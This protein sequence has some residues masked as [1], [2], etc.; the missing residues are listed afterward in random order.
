MPEHTRRALKSSASKATAKKG[1][2]PAARRRTDQERAADGRRGTRQSGTGPSSSWGCSRRR[3]QPGSTSGR[4]RSGGGSAAWRATPSPSTAG[5][6]LLFYADMADHE[7]PWADERPGEPRLDPRRPARRELRHVHGRRAGV[8]VFDVN[9]FDEAYLGH[10]T[11]D[12][13]R[14]RCE[15][16]AAGLAQGVARTRSSSDLV[17][18]YLRAYIDQVRHFVESDRDHDWALRLE[19]AAGTGPRRPARGPAASRASTCSTG[20]RGRGL[21]A[22]LPRRPASGRIEGRERK[23]VLTAYE[24]Y[25][26]DDPGR[27][28]GSAADRLPPQGRRR[29]DRL[30]HRQRRPP[31]VQRARRGPHARRWRTTSC[32][33]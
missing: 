21:R 19:T 17:D 4:R 20:H 25:L 6:R 33:R 18:R 3:T 2:T 7:D 29:Q 8:L 1:T 31:G 26:D 14:L 24:T 16:G 32:S 27:P 10:F 9:D 23:V 15:R 13:R 30:R 12:L 5:R 28:S 22:A 11:W